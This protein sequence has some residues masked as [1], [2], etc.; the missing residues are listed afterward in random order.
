MSPCSA[1]FTGFTV[2]LVNNRLVYIPMKAICDNSPRVMDAKG[3]TWERVLSIT[4]QP[5][6][7]AD[8]DKQRSHII[9]GAIAF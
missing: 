5:H 1:G 2:G 6:V 4:G 3:R 8:M 9:S 7:A